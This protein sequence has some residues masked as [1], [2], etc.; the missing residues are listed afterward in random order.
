MP[1]LSFNFDHHGRPVVELYVSVCSAEREACRDEGR[2]IPPAVL[3]HALIDT[4]AGRTHVDLGTLARLAISPASEG[5][6]Y[7][8][9]GTG[10]QPRDV[11][12]LDLALAGDKPGPIALD[13]QVFG[14]PIAHDLRIE[15]LLGRDVLGDCMLTYDG[16]NR[17]F[18]LAYNPPA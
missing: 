14:S 5:L 9:T 1:V 16:I 2:D 6:I 17:R 10:P 7:T 18:T 8:A 3:I 11:Y 12:L 4:G 15:M 13:L